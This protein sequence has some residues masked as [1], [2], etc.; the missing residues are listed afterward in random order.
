MVIKTFESFVPEVSQDTRSLET[1]AVSFLR[2]SNH[3]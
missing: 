3:N 1:L 2:V